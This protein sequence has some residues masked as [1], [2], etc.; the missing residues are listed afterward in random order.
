[1]PGPTRQQPA[2]IQVGY[3]ELL[4]RNSDFRN[5][6]AAR[7]VS[8]C[9][10]WFNT[11]AILA[12]LR[13]I[14][15][16]SASAFAGV[17]IL[18]TLPT[19]FAAPFAG[20]AADRFSRKR[21][22][23]AADLIRAALVLAMLSVTWVPHVGWLYLLVIGQTLTSTFFE[24]ART[25]LLPDLVRPGE[26]TAANAVGAALWSSMLALGSAA[27]GLTTAWLG[28]EVALVVDAGTYLLSAAFLLRVR[29]PAWDRAPVEAGSAV[30]A[31]FRQI[32]QGAAW[33]GSRPRVWS[34][35]LVKAGW[36]VAGGTTLVLT[37]LGERVHA[38]VA[39]PMIAVTALYVARGVG[40][41]VGP[42]LARAAS[43]SDPAA[44]ER[45]IAVGYA[46]G[47]VFYVAVA[48]APNLGLAVLAVALAHLGGSTI[49]VF[50]TVRL[51]QLVPTHVRGRVFAFEN[52]AFTVV[53]ALSTWLFGLA[54]DAEGA[55]VPWVTSAVGWL[56]CV[57][58]LAWTGRGLWLGWARDE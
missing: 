4:R 35:A 27:G 39:G 41:G 49:W 13:H 48:F 55:S 11:L 10:D 50:S 42:F 6:F 18:K 54:M 44:M 40:T 53:V 12:L 31:G 47:A 19:V 36:S 29:E 20:V 34:L 32:A 46:S 25:A 9:G 17:L 14:G 23:L 22:M 57:P 3:G 24:P 8:L 56:L 45:M 38:G 43:R 15:D 1:M 16:S 51:Q 2:P 28:W 33:V 26:L 52:A 58:A 30:L 37:V 21:I 7:A 5:L